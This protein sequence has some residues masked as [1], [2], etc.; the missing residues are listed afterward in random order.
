MNDLLQ[1]SLPPLLR[2]IEFL[3]LTRSGIQ[4]SRERES[5]N[6]ARKGGGEATP[7]PSSPRYLDQNRGG[8]L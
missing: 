8:F 6:W 3:P 7:P 2:L 4:E 1:L 5:G